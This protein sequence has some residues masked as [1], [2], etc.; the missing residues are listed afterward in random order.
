MSGDPVGISDVIARFRD[1]EVIAIQDSRAIPTSSRTRPPDPARGLPASTTSVG[2]ISEKVILDPRS[3]ISLQY[4][5]LSDTESLGE[6]TLTL[7]GHVEP[8]DNDLTDHGSLEQ[9]KRALTVTNTAGEPVRLESAVPLA[10]L[11]IVYQISGLHH[12]AGPSGAT[13]G[14]LVVPE[15]VSLVIEKTSVVIHF[16][17][18]S[19]SAGPVGIEDVSVQSGARRVIE[20]RKVRAISTSSKTRPPDSFRGLKA[21]TISEGTLSKTIVLE[22]DFGI[23]LQYTISGATDSI[24]AARLTF[25]GHVAVADDHL[26]DK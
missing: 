20:G 1:H 10:P 8:V 16:E 17:P 7:F 6:V 13:I 24:G 9:I 21:S 3:L 19:M 22:P 15:N 18:T 12:S 4:K 26:S 25:L 2:T 14:V 23:S 11:R 5:I